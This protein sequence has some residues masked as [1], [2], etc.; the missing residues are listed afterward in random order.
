MSD[1]LISGVILAAGRS[2]RMGRTKALLKVMDRTLLERQLEAMADLKKIAVVIPGGV[3]YLDQVSTKPPTAIFEVQNNRVDLGPF[4]SLRLG[5]EATGM[6]NPVLVVPVDCPTTR[7]IVN[8]LAAQ[9]SRLMPGAEAPV[10]W[11]VPVNQG[12]IGHPVL[13]S[14]NAARLVTNAR[15]TDTL[16]DVLTNLPSLEI[17]IGSPLVNFNLNRPMDLD[18]FL[19]A[20]EADEETP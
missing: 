16:R 2:R 14:P 11:I 7:E 17:E 12:K 19:S 18:D 9:A 10:D 15:L 3:S 20:L 4:H 6:T 5:I 1:Q 8:T 13:L